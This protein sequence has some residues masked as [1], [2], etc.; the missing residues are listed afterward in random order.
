MAQKPSDEQ[1]RLAIDAI[2]TKYDKDM[3]GTLDYSEV[4][5]VINDSFKNMGT[6][7]PV[8]DDDVKKFL[9]AVDQNNDG[10]ITKQELF[11]IFKRIIDSHFH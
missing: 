7:R 2:F 11:S 9:G 3:S 8:N 1:L 4:K 5:C 6:S 10:K